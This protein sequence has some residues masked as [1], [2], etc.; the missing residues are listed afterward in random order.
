LASSENGTVVWACGSQATVVLS[1]D[2]GSTWKNVG[3]KGFN[4]LEFRSIAAFDRNNALIA[5]AGSPAVILRTKDGGKSWRE[6]L[7][8][9]EKAAFFD[10]LKFFDQNR[11][12]AVSD[13]V[14]GK[15][16]IL[17]TDDGGES[18]RE[19][20]RESLPPL[21]EGEAAF[22]A[23]NSALAVSGDGWAWIGTGGVEAAESKVYWTSDFGESWNVSYSPI[24]SGKSSGVFSLRL[25]SSGVLVAVGGDYRPDTPVSHHAAYSLDRGK[26]WLV[27][28]HGPKLFRSAAVA[29][30]TIEPN[31]TETWF[32]VGPQGTD[33]TTDIKHWKVASNVGFHALEILDK[34]RLVAVGSEGRIGIADVRVLPKQP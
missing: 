8:R 33:Y 34:E 20:K 4:G 14:D 1:D 29:S 11:G 28:V 7:R 30:H 9:E 19:I 31:S 23:S 21:T 25:A 13:P 12:F 5:S 3:P 27:P 16:L 10:G 22:A 17:K 15:W 32:S 24:P 18:W 26:T 2:G 6:V